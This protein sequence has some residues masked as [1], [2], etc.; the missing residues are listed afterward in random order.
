[1]ISYGKQTIDESD[2]TAVTD[3]LRSG[4]LTQGFHVKE[5]EDAFAD[6]CNASYAVACSN[7]TAALHLAYLAIGLGKNDSIITSPLTFAATA[8]AALYAGARP[9]LADIDPATHNI[10]PSEIEK[11]ISY[12]NANDN[13]NRLKAIVPVHFAGLPCDMETIW[14]IANKNNLMVIEDACHALGA[15]WQ[16]KDENWHKIG[17]C[18]HSHAAVFSF[19]PVK[20][21]TT[22]E[23]GVITTNDKDIYEKLKLF[24]SHGIT[25]DQNS[26]INNNLAFTENNLN[27]WYYEMQELGFNYRIT[28]MQCALGTNQIKKTDN[29][30]TRRR[31]IVAIY[32]EALNPYSHINLPIT[33]QNSHSANHLYTVQIAFDT[34]GTTKN[35]F[36]QMML[37]NNISLQV[38]YIPIHLQP[39]YQKRF[40]FKEG[41]FLE[42]ESFYNSTVS[43]PIYPTLSDTDLKH[44]IGSIIEALN[45]KKI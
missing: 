21:I 43:L 37:K 11:A 23:G 44:I 42:S 18:F 4:W 2:I 1:M 36:F 39:Y 35:T 38:H 20:S 33:P 27:P 40:H 3:A 17:S 13:D 25:K 24:R 15:K 34:L 30:M 45:L 19:H 22:G 16:D 5:F 9:Y 28:D 8:N 12:I 7:G 14:D 29:F 41:D 26:F 6:Y 10:S 32:N 31:E